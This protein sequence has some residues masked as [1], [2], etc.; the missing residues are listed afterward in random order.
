MNKWLSTNYVC[1]IFVE[2]DYLYVATWIV[3]TTTTTWLNLALSRIC[4]GKSQVY[5]FEIGSIVMTA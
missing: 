5:S 1:G 2:F 3:Y 4:D